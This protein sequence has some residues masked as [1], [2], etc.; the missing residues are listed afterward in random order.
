QQA[1]GSVT[2][3]HG[4][5]ATSGPPIHPSL[6]SPAAGCGRRRSKEAIPRAADEACVQQPWIALSPVARSRSGAHGGKGWGK[7]AARGAHGSVCRTLMPMGPV[8]VSPPFCRAY[9]TTRPANRLVHD[10][11]RDTVLRRRGAE[12]SS[13]STAGG[14][15]AT[16]RRPI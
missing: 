13:L 14:A 9:D 10:W 12:L 11:R 2:A 15:V 7:G 8:I 3:R 4:G 6:L 1:T 5:R 16:V